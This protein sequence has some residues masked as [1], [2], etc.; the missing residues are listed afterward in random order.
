MGLLKILTPLHTK[1]TAGKHPPDGGFFTSES[2]HGGV[3]EITRKNSIP[4]I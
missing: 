3:S 1:L 2:T 4:V